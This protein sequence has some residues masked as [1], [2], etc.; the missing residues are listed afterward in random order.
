MIADDVLTDGVA[1]GEPVDREV[2]VRV[3]LAG[4]ALRVTGD[5]RSSLKDCQAISSSRRAIASFSTAS[6]VSTKDWR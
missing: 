2:V 1:R 5:L 3:G 6:A 4:A